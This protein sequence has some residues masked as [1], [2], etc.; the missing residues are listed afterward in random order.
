[1]FSENNIIMNNYLSTFG[2][3]ILAFKF[4]FFVFEP[5]YCFFIKMKFFRTTNFLFFQCLEYINYFHNSTEIN[6]IFSFFV[7][8]FLLAHFSHIILPLL[9]QSNLFLLSS[10]AYILTHDLTKYILPPRILSPHSE[11][12]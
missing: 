8:S 2:T 10:V 11:H 5:C 3:S 4:M 6:S 7:F 12:T 1:M 9:L